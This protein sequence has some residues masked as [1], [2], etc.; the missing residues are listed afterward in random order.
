MASP[1]V[2]ATTNQIVN[3]LEFLGYGAEVE[4][5]GTDDEGLQHVIAEHPY[6]PGIHIWITDAE[7]RFSSWFGVNEFAKSHKQEFLTF[8]NDLNCQFS[9]KFFVTDWEGEP[10]FICNLIS[11]ASYERVAFGRL[12]SIWDDVWEFLFASDV[13][14][15]FFV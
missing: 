7:F 1:Q 13:G 2:E 15:P 10:R 12:I 6:R 8:V 9:A 14:K 3:H 11:P 5:V 4:T